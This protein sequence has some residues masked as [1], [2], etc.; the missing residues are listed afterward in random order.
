MFKQEQRGA[1]A[2]GFENQ[3]T[4]TFVSEDERM[5]QMGFENETDPVSVN[6]QESAKTTLEVNTKNPGIEIKKAGTTDEYESFEPDD[7]FREDFRKELSVAGYDAIQGL[8]ILS[9]MEKSND[10]FRYKDA[11]TMKKE[12]RY[13]LTTVKLMQTTIKDIPGFGQ[14]STDA[15]AYWEVI[16]DKVN[17]GFRLKKDLSTN[18]NLNPALAI[19]ALV[20]PKNNLR[21]D[22]STALAVL[23][24]ITVK[25]ELG[26]TAFNELYKTKELLIEPLK[27]QSEHGTKKHRDANLND[28]TADTTD[29]KEKKIESYDELIPGDRGHFMNFGNMKGDAWNAEFVLYMGKVGGKH[30]FRGHPFDEPMSAEKLV[31][32]LI[33]EYKRFL[34]ENPLAVN[35]IKMQKDLKKNPDP[36]YPNPYANDIVGGEAPGLYNI[37]ERPDVSKLY[38][39]E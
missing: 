18:E 30:M 32:E 31:D 15:T 12:I 19:E 13:R 33:K 37:I 29:K 2:G 22:C 23:E 39:L 4:E 5:Q 27:R 16:A 1:M 8:E 20:D 10:T 25:R 3:E 24:F 38:G 11:D 35:E 34:D 26:E 36:L 6:E 14:W 21:V 28:L 7:T 9:A 17:P